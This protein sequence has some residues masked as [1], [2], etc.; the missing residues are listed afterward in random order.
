MTDDTASPLRVLDNPELERRAALLRRMGWMRAGYCMCILGVH[1]G[2]HT[3]VLWVND[4]P[5]EP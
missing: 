1:C 5:P 4:L 2:Q 3:P